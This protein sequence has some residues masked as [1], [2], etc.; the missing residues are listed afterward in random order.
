MFYWKKHIRL[1]IKRLISIFLWDEWAVQLWSQ[2]SEDLILSRI[3]GPEYKGFYVDVGAHHPR[4]F[5]TQTSFIEGA[6]MG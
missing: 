1:S 6:G 5:L 3:F 2:E 4:R